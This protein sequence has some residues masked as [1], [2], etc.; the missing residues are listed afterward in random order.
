MKY[1]RL[2]LFFLFTFLITWACWWSLA[3]FVNLNILHHGQV[4]YIVILFIGGLGPAFSPFITFALTGTK[5]GFK[6]YLC[7][8]FRW[9]LNIFW[10]ILPFIITFGASILS[11]YFLIMLSGTSFTLGMNGPWYMIFPLF[12]LMLAGGGLEEFGW[13][14]LAL[15]EME[16]Y[17]SPL[18]SGLVIGSIWLIWHYP[19]IVIKGAYYAMDLIIFTIAIIGLSLILTWIYDHTQSIII[20]IIAHASYNMVI[21]MGIFGYFLQ[22]GYYTKALINSIILLLTGLFLL[23]AFPKAKVNMKLSNATCV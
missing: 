17:Y 16:K 4:Y 7:R 8:L 18:F 20:C 9:R 2:V 6:N 5:R 22:D 1:I 19:L 23:I 15:P 10:Y 3:L 14:G 11:V 21:A 13:R 12:F